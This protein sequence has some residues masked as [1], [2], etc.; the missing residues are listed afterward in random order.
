MRSFPGRRATCARRIYVRLD[1]KFI[2]RY[3]EEC[4]PCAAVLNNGAS[5]PCCRRRNHATAAVT[6]TLLP[7]VPPLP[8]DR[9]GA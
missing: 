5:H 4:N 8:P 6:T 2:Y 1:L 3:I 7:V 9:T